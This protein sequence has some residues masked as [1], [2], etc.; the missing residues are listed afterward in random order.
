MSCHESPVCEARGG[1]VLKNIAIKKD[2][3]DDNHADNDD[4]G[5]DDID[6]ND[7]KETCGRLCKSVLLVPPGDCRYTLCVRALLPPSS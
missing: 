7:D 6:L 2:C 5:D 1:E 3:G 4:D